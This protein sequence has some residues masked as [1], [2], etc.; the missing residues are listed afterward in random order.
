MVI[1]MSTEEEIREVYSDS[2]RQQ[3]KVVFSHGGNLPFLAGASSGYS[4]KHLY[5]GILSEEDRE[6]LTRLLTND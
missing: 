4:V 1:S 6:F 3:E 2:I 5:D